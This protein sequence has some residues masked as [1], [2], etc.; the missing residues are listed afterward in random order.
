MLP[1][2]NGIVEILDAV[3]RVNASQDGC[4]VHRNILDALIGLPMTETQYKKG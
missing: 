3:V 2:L 1:C 4:S